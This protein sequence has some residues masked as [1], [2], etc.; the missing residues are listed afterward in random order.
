VKRRALATLVLLVAAGALIATSPPRWSIA[1]RQGGVVSLARGEA[2]TR[3]SLA[4]DASHELGVRLRF[5]PTFSDPTA[6]AQLRVRTS[7]RGLTTMIPDRI[8]D[9]STPDAGRPW[10][11]DLP[12]AVTTSPSHL[13]IDIRIERISGD[14][15]VSVAWDA[16]AETGQRGTSEVPKSASVR[17]VLASPSGP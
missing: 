9:S 8:L 17:I 16:E 6:A 3:F 13:D 1:H 7:A 10:D 2:S 14:Q 15:P 12:Y 5:T 11:V 4:A